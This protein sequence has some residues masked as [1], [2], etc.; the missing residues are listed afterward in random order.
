MDGRRA[1]SS[2]SVYIESSGVIP[3]VSPKSYSSRPAVRVGHDEGSTAKECDVV[4]RDE[5]KR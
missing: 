4:V 2:P 3:A 5:R 1:N